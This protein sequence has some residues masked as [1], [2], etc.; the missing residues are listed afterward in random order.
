MKNPLLTVD[1]IIV[2]KDGSI[3]LV[4]RG[5]T[6]FNGM[7]AIPGG[8]VEYGERVEDAAVREAKEETGLE[9]RLTELLGVYSEPGRDPRGHT[10]SVAFL[11]EKIGGKLKGGSDASD[12]KLFKRIPRSLAF[13]HTKIL[14]D[15]KIRL[16]N[17]NFRS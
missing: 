8:I 6:P 14:R 16:R 5:R 11:A 9:V 12:A 13:D 10:V 17:L 7:W 3:V 1:I 2:H 4:R 15:A